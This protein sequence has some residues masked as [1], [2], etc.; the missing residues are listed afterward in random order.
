MARLPL[1]LLTE[2]RLLLAKLQCCW[3]NCNAAAEAAT[4]STVSA[5][6]VPG[7]AAV[8][9]PAG[10]AWLQS[11]VVAGAAT[12]D[13]IADAITVADAIAVADADGKAAVAAPIA[14]AV[15]AAMAATTT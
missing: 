7:G 15:V 1:L 5:A 10:E 12:A 4:A 13:C 8:A 6:V 2:L 9:T 14:H 11:N 3:P